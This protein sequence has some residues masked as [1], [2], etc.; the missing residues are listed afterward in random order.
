MGSSEV[1]VVRKRAKKNGFTLIEIM[2]VVSIIAMLLAIA[3]PSFVKTRDTARLN[4]CLANLKSVDGA[5]MQ[6]AME[7]RKTDGDSVTWAD[8]APSYI[9]ARVTCPWGFSYTLQPIGTPTYCPVVG[10]H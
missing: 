5:K 8:L 3:A 10:H 9:K 1:I 2:I 7:C 4:S 6:W